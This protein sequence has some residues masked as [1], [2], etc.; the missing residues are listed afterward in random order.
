LETAFTGLVA[1]HLG[2]AAF[3][4]VTLAEHISHLISS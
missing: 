1:Q 2:A 4:H 3:A